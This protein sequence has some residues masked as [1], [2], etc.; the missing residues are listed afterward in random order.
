MRGWKRSR[1]SE[2]KSA[3]G[4]ATNLAVLVWRICEGSLPRSNLMN[5]DELSPRPRWWNWYL[6]WPRAYR[7]SNGLRVKI[8]ADDE[9]RSPLGLDRSDSSIEWAQRRVLSSGLAK[10]VGTWRLFGRLCP[11]LRIGGLGRNLF[12]GALDVAEAAATLI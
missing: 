6:L 11:E 1:I 4:T 8:I 3:G 12:E 2:L 7:V 10:L 5:S 9:I